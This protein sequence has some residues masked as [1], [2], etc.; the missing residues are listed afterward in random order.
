MGAESVRRDVCESRVRTVPS[1]V[2]V[3]SSDLV[4][5]GTPNFCEGFL[6][7]SGQSV[8]P[9]GAVILRLWQTRRVTP[10]RVNNGLRIAVELCV[11]AP[12]V[13]GRE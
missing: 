2:M 12:R 4:V 6:L 9:Q 13:F 1:L 3:E 8:G 10:K 5:M 11:R 7:R